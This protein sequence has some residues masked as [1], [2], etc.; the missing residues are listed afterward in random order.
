[1]R[2]LLRAVLSEGAGNIPTFF[3]FYI[4]RLSNGVIIFL[5]PGT[6][7]G[8]VEPRGVSSLVACSQHNLKQLVNDRAVL[9]LCNSILST[10]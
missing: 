8:K 4:W 3:F 10:H 1:M 7:A 2:D 6:E 5:L 9:F